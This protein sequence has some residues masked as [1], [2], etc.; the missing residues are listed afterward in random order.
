MKILLF[1]GSGSAGGSVLRACLASPD[2][3]SVRAI[4]RRPLQIAADPK[5]EVVLHQDF[6]DY[7]AV[8][9]AFLDVDACLDALGISVSQ[10]SGE[11]EY[12]RITEGFAL[13]AAAALRAGSPAAVF[14]YVSGQGASLNSRFMWARVKAEAERELIA[15]F[16]AVCWRPGSIDG[17]PS[18]SEPRLYKTL[19]P[20]LRLLRP[21]RSLYVQGE[22][23]G[24]AM[25]LATREGM[26]GRI[27]E[28]REIRDLADRARV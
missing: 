25:L 4:V 13:A 6:L 2:V 5:L 8:A 17:E 23:I 18:A 14:H 11:A 16:D 7:S 28:N 24:R 21:F 15:R 12:R 26:R 10:V 1:G 9:A 22:D 19:R 3:E 20:V 27:V